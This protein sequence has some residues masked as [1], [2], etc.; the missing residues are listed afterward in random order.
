MSLFT[1]VIIL[2]L[3]EQDKRIVLE[4]LQKSSCSC[5][6]NILFLNKMD[7][8]KYFMSLGSYIIK[9]KKSGGIMRFISLLYS[10][11]WKSRNL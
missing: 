3:R 2:G 8:L 9:N 10:S 1:V 4:L 7:L 11:L 5:L 6:R